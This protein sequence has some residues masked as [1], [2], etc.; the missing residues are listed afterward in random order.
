MGS[1]TREEGRQVSERAAANGTDWGLGKNLRAVGEFQV[2]GK[3]HLNE[4]GDFF[5]GDQAIRV[6]KAVITD[7]HKTGGQDVKNLEKAILP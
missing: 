2:E 3:G 5:E 6:H 7:F 1:K 4:G